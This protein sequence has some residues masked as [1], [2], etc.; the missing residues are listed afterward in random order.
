MFLSEPTD[1]YGPRGKHNLL[2]FSYFGCSSGIHTV[3][4]H[5]TVVVL[6]GESQL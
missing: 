3:T 1:L 2:K 4:L 5:L 6:Q